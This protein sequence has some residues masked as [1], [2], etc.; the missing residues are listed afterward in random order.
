MPTTNP[1]LAVE[2]LSALQRS[3]S[4][5]A[6]LQSPSKLLTNT[7]TG[8]IDVVINGPPR[9]AI[10]AAIGELETM[11]VRLVALWPYDVGG[12]ATAFFFNRSGTDGAQIDM[13]Y[14]PNGRGHYS[15][16]S[17]G[18]IESAGQDERFP[19][20]ARPALAIYLYSKRLWKGQEAQLVHLRSEVDELENVP[21]LIERLVTS[22][23][24]ARR[25]AE[26]PVSVPPRIAGRLLPRMKWLIA[27]LQHPVGFWIHCPGDRA[28]LARSL[29]ERFGRVL[30][31]STAKP[32]VG[33]LPRSWWW[34]WR[35]VQ[36]TRL[37]PGIVVT[38][39]DTPPRLGPTPDL[40]VTSSHLDTAASATISAM[41]Q[42]YVE[43]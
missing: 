25:I 30:V 14:D 24:L 15:I 38:W 20:V 6:L 17:T 29:A 26:V 31:Y 19:V 35:A 8:D 3:G 9:Q 16:R 32:T 10:T 28:D 43:R 7:P 33:S 13:L 2:V 37:R 18:L 39:G 41:S 4:E 34:Y 21:D 36:P 27:R 42:R 12:T 1:G 23:R 40:T 5:L 11:G 22:R